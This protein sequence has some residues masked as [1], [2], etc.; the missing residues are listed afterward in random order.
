MRFMKVILLLPIGQ[1]KL[2]LQTSAEARLA[3]VCTVCTAQVYSVPSV[4][5]HHWVKQNACTTFF[6]RKDI[7]TTKLEILEHLLRQG[8]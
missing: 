7:A 1:N 5:L 6:D 8:R 4:Q 3:P 2:T